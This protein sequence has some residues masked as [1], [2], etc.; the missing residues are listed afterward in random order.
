[1]TAKGIGYAILPSYMMPT[2]QYPG[3]IAL[4]LVRPA[5]TRQL[6]WIQ[7]TGRSLSPAALQFQKTAARVL[8]SAHATAVARRATV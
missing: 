6:S 1:M 5:I 7:Q 8:A 3:L 2:E 4:Q